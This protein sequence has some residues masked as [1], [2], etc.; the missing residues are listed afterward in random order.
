MCAVFVVFLSLLSGLSHQDYSSIPLSFPNTIAKWMCV[1]VPLVFSV[2]TNQLLFWQTGATE[3]QK[4]PSPPSSSWLSP[5]SSI[6][7]TAAGT[8]GFSH[9]LLCPFLSLT[10]YLSVQKS[11]AFKMWLSVKP[12]HVQ[13]SLWT[14]F[15]SPTPVHWFSLVRSRLIWLH[16]E[17]GNGSEEGKG[18]KM[19]DVL[20]Q[21][22]SRPQINSHNCSELITANLLPSAPTI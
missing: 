3:T 8:F 20:I 21:V 16:R 15:C 4:A 9:L 5:L 7:L 6:H 12:F 14:L 13:R 18:E 10:L 2:P 19:N 11:L 17:A 1:V 22:H